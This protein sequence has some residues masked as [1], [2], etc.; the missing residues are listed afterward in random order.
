MPSTPARFRPFMAIIRTRVC[1]GGS[2][3]VSPSPSSFSELLR[4]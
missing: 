1:S 4:A 2:M 3:P